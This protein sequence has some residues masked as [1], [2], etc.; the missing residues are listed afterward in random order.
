MRAHKLI[1]QATLEATHRAQQLEVRCVDAVDVVTV[2]S[3]VS[4]VTRAATTPKHG[5]L[6]H[7]V[8]SSSIA[9]HGCIDRRTG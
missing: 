9:S 5:G 4:V 6:H 7:D 3:C 2:S 8:L 1:E